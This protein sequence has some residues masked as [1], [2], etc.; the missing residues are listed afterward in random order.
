MTVSTRY[1]VP[2]AVVLAI[3]M[4]P[5]LIHSYAGVTVDDGLR[6]RDLNVRIAG[7]SGV[8]TSRK[9]DWVKRRLASEDWQERRYSI[10]GREV[11]LF[12]GRSY[13]ATALY[14]HPE[15]AL[16][17]GIDFQVSGLVNIAGAPAFAL[18]GRTQPNLAMYALHANESFIADP[19]RFQIRNATMG[20]FRGR[21]AMT[22]FF[23]LERGAPISDDP[24]TS[25]A[26]RVLEAALVDFR[27]A[28]E[29][30]ATKDVR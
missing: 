18:D 30:T 10:G 26:A 15:L 28:F 24:T 6:A 20:I 13:D 1:V 14:H 29:G 2:L 4:V 11:V 8:E 23:V 3:G 17:Y 19:I 9:P 21:S 27:R 7:S 12:I 16:A 22:L 25:A 5:T